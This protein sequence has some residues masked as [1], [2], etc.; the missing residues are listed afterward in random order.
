VVVLPDI[1]PEG[2]LAVA[3][4]VVQAVARIAAERWASTPV[5]A[6]VGL[7]MARPD[8]DVAS[9]LRRAD[10]EAYAAKRAGGHRVSASIE[11]QRVSHSGVRASVDADEPRHARSG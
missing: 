8:D 7:T 11:P 6:S 3:E 10:A 5:T 1:S 4:R 2:T 9:L